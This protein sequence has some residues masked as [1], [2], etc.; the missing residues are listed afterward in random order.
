VTN[1]R[2]EAGKDVA[3]GCCRADVEKKGSERIHVEMT[4]H[5]VGEGFVH[6]VKCQR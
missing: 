2:V 3:L 4:A 1:G 6:N 5:I